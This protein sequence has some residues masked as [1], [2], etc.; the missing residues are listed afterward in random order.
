M[1]KAGPPVPQSAGKEQIMKKRNRTS[2]FDDRAAPGRNAGRSFAAPGNQTRRPEPAIKPALAHASPKRPFGDYQARKNNENLWIYGSHAAVSAL[3]NK[4]RTCHRLL[5][6]QEAAARLAD[7]LADAAIR[8]GD[9]LPPAE[10]V[11]RAEIDALMSRGAVHQGIAVQADPLPEPSLDEIAHGAPQDAVIVVLDQV[12][13]PHN[14]GAI[15]RS[16][17]AFGALAVL[18]TD[19]HS[20]DQGATLAKSAS[21]ATERVPFIRVVNLAR[22]LEELKKLDFWCLG[23]DANG[24]QTLAQAKSNNRIALVLGA[25]GQGLRRLTAEKC[26]ALVRLPMN[27]AMPSLNVS[28]AAAIAL[29]ELRRG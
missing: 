5:L 17:D 7:D 26:D 6:T 1:D 10:I 12:T 22:A 14:V 27:G 16:A 18:S 11:D 20:P 21:G 25:E 2:G 23:L 28:N 8:R 15:L 13:D 4:F 9:Q 29:Y 19:R 24:T 3:G